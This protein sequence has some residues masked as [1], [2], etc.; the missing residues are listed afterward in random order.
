MTRPGPESL[1]VRMPAAPA[2]EFVEAARAALAEGGF[3]SLVL[4]KPRAS[5]GAPKAVR[6]RLIA[7]KGKPMLSFVAVHP[8]RDVTRNLAIDP[9]LAE[10]A[11]QLDPD[12]APSFAHATLHARDADTHL[13]VSRKGHATL[14]RHARSDARPS[15]EGSDAAL[16]AHDR[17][18]A[19]R[20]PLELPFLTE[21][22]ITDSA[23]RLVPAMARKWRQIDKFLEVLDHALDALPAAGQEG[24]N[25]RC[26]SST[27]AAARAT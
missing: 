13:L 15:A 4:S 24:A 2:A 25:G 17:E 20:L 14:R 10:V 16:P 8:T 9:G 12:H 18:R 5:T 1:P 27:T 21:L 23:H 3:E 11:A 7:L 6:V 19:R 22:G 26:A